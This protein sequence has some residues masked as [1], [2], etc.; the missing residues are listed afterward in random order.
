MASGE[1]NRIIFG[2]IAAIIAISLVTG[3]YVISGTGSMTATTISSAHYVE[4]VSVLGPIPPFNPGGPVISVSLENVAG[5][6][7][8]SLNATL[9]LP[10][11]GS[12]AHYLFAF[13]SVN[14]SHPLTNGQSVK[15][16]L[17]AIGAGFDSSK[18]YPLVVTGTLESSLAFNFTE[19][20]MIVPPS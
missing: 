3:A 14:S 19:Q 2:G 20:V 9:Y 15:T 12:S 1:D 18:A 4:V 5:V 7:I 17:T 10:S 6:S 13:S 16:T 11:T 8:T